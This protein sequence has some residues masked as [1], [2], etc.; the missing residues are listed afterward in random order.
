MEVEL[1]SERMALDRSLRSVQTRIDGF[2]QA[3]SPPRVPDADWI[4]GGVKAF[5]TAMVDFTGA[6]SRTKDL[7]LHW[8]REVSRD[9]RPY[10]D[11]TDAAI[12]ADYQTLLQMVPVLQ[13][14]IAFLA[15]HGRDVSGHGLMLSTIGDAVREILA[16]WEKPVRSRLPGLRRIIIPAEQSERFQQLLK[17]LG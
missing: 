16:Q 1:A 11:A 8:R 10:D 13:E 4:D 15:R 9:H 7:E 14:R 3:T 17:E 5:H 12:R 6:F 2:D